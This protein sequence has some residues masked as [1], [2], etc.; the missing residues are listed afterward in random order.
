MPNT[1]FVG[2]VYRRFDQLPSTNDYAVQLLANP[3]LWYP[4][5]NAKIPEGAVIQADFQSAGKGQYGSSWQSAG[6]ENLLLSVILY[7]DWLAAHEQFY[8]GMAVAL[9]LIPPMSNPTLSIR[10]KWPNDLYINDKKCAGI[11]IQNAIAGKNIQYSIVGIGMN[12]N[13][14]VF[15]PALPNPTSLA[16]AYGHPFDRQEIADRLLERLERRYLQLRAGHQA[17]IKK[18]YTEHLYRLNEPAT[19]RRVADQ[20]L[21]EGVIRDVSDSGRLLLETA[22]GIESFELKEITFQ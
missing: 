11:L 4:D 21:F 22:R 1:L 3:E 6:G 13:Q 19:F 10:L 14:T 7:P 20:M 15:D 2:K 16:L 9:A 5:G 8:L 17:R 18:E 12:V